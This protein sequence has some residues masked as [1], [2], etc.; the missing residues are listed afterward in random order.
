MNDLT[1]RPA[2]LGPALAALIGGTYDL[3]PAIGQK[4]IHVGDHII[5]ETFTGRLIL[6]AHSPAAVELGRHSEGASKLAAA[7]RMATTGVAA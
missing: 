2:P 6:D 4:V 3:E 7:F 5:S 1:H